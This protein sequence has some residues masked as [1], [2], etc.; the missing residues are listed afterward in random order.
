MKTEY[1]GKT[2]ELQL[3]QFGTTYEVKC[4]GR[5]HLLFSRGFKSKER[6][7]AFFDQKEAEVSLLESRWTLYE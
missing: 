6:A 5:G 2:L 4:Y 7:L 1:I 3:I